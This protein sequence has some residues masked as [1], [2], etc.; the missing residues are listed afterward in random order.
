MEHENSCYEVGGATLLQ[1]G[2][3]ANEM[4][5]DTL[6]FVLGA[7]DQLLEQRILDK[8][9]SLSKCIDYCMNKG[10]SIEI[11]CGKTGFAPVTPDQHF[12]WVRE[13]FGISGTPYSGK[14]IRFAPASA[15]DSADRQT[16]GL[17]SLLD[18]LD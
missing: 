8:K 16:I 4:E 9:L 1:L 12:A 5:A 6:E 7:M 17:S 13:Y 2:E 3:P 18:D 11:K 10:H 14:V 15:P